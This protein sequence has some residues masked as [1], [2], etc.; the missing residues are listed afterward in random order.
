MTTPSAPP[1]MNQAQ[2]AVTQAADAAQ[3][4]VDAAANAVPPV[5]PVHPYLDR[6]GLIHGLFFR[7]EG[8]TDTIITTDAMFMLIFWFSAFFFVL[9]MVLMVYWTIK[10]RR[11]PGVAPPRSSAHNTPLEVF[12]TVVPS[13]SMLVMFFL[14]FWGYM[15]KVVPV[16]GAMELNVKAQKWDWTITYPDG[17]QSGQLVELGGRNNIKINVLPEDTDVKLRMSSIDVIHAFW[18]PDY[19]TKMDVFPNRYTGY[20]FHTPKLGPGDDHPEGRYRDHWVFCAEYCGDLHSEMA[21]IIRIMSREDYEKWLKGQ[22]STGDPVLDGKKVWQTKCATCHTTD[23]K[24]NI[25]PTWLNM[26]G[27]PVEFTDGTSLVVDENYIRESILNPSAKIVKGK[28][29][30]M[31]SFQGNITDEEIENVIAFMK[32]ISEAGKTEGGAETPAEGGEGAPAEG[33]DHEGGEGG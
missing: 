18:L 5:P 11:R 6:G 14:G 26:Y 29:N 16:G 21:A 2:D 25:G 9:L 28:Q 1:V 7:N 12:W 4:A 8:H 10:Y 31:T 24:D 30:Q 3:G 27:E 33:A 32:S 17:T 15:N 13:S 20:G 23:G 22:G 19:R